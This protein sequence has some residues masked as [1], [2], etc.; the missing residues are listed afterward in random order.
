M[1]DT[2]LGNRAVLKGF[3]MQREPEKKVAFRLRFSSLVFR[4]KNCFFVGTRKP[5]RTHHTQLATKLFDDENKIELTSR[6]VF[7]NVFVRSTRF[8]SAWFKV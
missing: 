2:L 3:K 5:P 4:V 7:S 6:G 1:G 8:V